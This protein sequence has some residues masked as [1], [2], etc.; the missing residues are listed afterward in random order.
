MRPVTRPCSLWLRIAPV[1]RAL[2]HYTSGDV[3]ELVRTKDVD[4][5]IHQN[6]ADPTAEDHHAR[7]SGG[8]RLGPHGVR[9]RD[10]DRHGH[11][12]ADRHEAKDNAGPAVM[13]SFLIAGRRLLAALCYAEL[14][15][16]VPT[17]GSSYTY[18]YTTIGE[19]FAWIIAWDLMLEFAL[20]AAVVARGWSGYLQDAFD[21]PPALFGEEDRVNVGA[22]YRG[23][24]RRGR[25]LG[26]RSPS[27]SPTRSS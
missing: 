17:A 26:I 23:G 12:H 24:A 2:R 11:L 19:I 3:N 27:S 16:A 20:G 4:D 25:G 9:H 15:A 10:R 1:P 13:I 6:D 5:V 18:A 7:P 22:V 21:L 8:C 14:A